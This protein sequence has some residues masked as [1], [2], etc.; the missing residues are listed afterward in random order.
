MGKDRQATWFLVFLACMIPAFCTG[1]M[2]M[3]GGYS[4][5]YGFAVDS[6]ANVYVGRDAW[7]RVY[8]GDREIRKLSPQTSRGYAFRMEHDELLVYAATYYYRMDLQGEVL[9]RI[10]PDDLDLDLHFYNHN[11]RFTAADGTRYRM[12]GSLLHG[13]RI[14]NLETGA[15]VWQQSA[16]EVVTMRIASVSLLCTLVSGAMALFVYGKPNDRSR[17]AKHR[18]E[19]K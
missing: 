8:Q 6:E 17:A 10:E 7:I 12:T 13:K 4:S 1:M 5:F 9:E 16:S 19:G 2:S 18:S 11:T 15:V 3:L 14:W